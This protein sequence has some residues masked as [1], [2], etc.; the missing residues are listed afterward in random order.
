MAFEITI[1]RLGWSMEEGTFVRWLKQDGDTISPGDPL[2]ELEGEKAAQDVEAVDAGVL[3]ISPESP[4]PGAIV[5]VGTVI[6]YLTAAGEAVPA[7]RC[8]VSGSIT[9]QDAQFVSGHS[10]DSG[11][12]ADPTVQG[13]V[14]PAAPP[15]VRRMAR[16]RGIDLTHVK[17][18]GPAGRIF[19]SDLHLD[20]PCDGSLSSA[21][22]AAVASPRA[23]RVAKELGIDWTGLSGSGRNGRVRERDVR[24]SAG[25]P[26][27]NAAPVGKLRSVEVRGTEIALTRHRRAVADQMVRSRQTTAPVTITT[28]IDATNL[29]SL[30]QQFKTDAATAP[31]YTDIVVKLVSIALADHR[32]LMAQW[33]DDQLIVPEVINIGIAV[34]TDAGLLVP[35]IRNVPSLT[36]VELSNVST[37]LIAQARAGLLK[38]NDIQGGVFTVTNLGAYG[39]DAFTPII[40]P[41]ETA[42]LGLGQIRRDP[43]VVENQIIPR[44]QM[45]LSLT[46]DHRIVD[47]APAARFLQSVRQALE[48]PSAWLLRPERE[49]R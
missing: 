32:M 24:A 29:V 8:V 5:A 12:M 43:A 17:G 22:N 44:D 1:P 27:E 21:K 46:F 11:S 15:S 41:P 39:I 35:V 47:G 14:T 49:P 30:R 42:I 9:A 2:F 10:A 25:S 31:S 28:R 33:S 18:S 16:E 40:N 34:D 38:L 37:K 6:G 45:T 7:S 20:A 19:A 36:L 13:A 26:I 4:K 23:R 48:S 3:R